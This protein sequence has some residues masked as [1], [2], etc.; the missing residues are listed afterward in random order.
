MRAKSTV[1]LSWLVTA[2][3]GCSGG[4]GGG[5]GFA[6][7]GVTGAGVIGQPCS[8]SQACGAGLYCY[9]GD[10]PE[11]KGLCTTNCTASADSDS[12]LLKYPNTS[13][14]VAG[15]CGAQCGDGLAC[16]VGSTCNADYQ[17]C[18]N[19]ANSCQWADDGFCDEPVACEPGTDTADCD[20]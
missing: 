8:A 15:V 16:P 4:G 9:D 19:A 2:V 18:V 10:T 6:D 20:F 12:C 17:V 14:L 13:C 3:L 11:L 5:G 1:A 7:G